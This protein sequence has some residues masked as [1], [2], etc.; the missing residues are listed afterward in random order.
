MFVRAE[1]YMASPIEINGTSVFDSKVSDFSS[2]VR[3][4]QSTI[5]LLQKD[6]TRIIPLM[7]WHALFCLRKSIEQRSSNSSY[8]LAFRYRKEIRLTARFIHNNYDFLR[9]IMK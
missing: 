7:R 4:S 3:I 2:L 1:A 9:W 6:L 8:K 5:S